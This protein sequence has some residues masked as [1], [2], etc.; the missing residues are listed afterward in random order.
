[1]AWKTLEAPKLSG[2]LSD[3]LSKVVDMGNIVT[4]ALKAAKSVAQVVKQ[5]SINTDPVQLALQAAAVGLKSAVDA[6]VQSFPSAYVLVVPPSPKVLIPASVKVALGSVTPQLSTELLNV[7]AKFAPSELTPEINTFLRQVFEAST[8]NGS[9]V[10][11]VL[12]S[13]N[14]TEDDSRPVL[15]Q[16]SYV[17][18]AYLVAGADG[19]ELLTPILSGLSAAM[20]SNSPV[21]LFPTDWP[22]PQGLVAKTVNASNVSLRWTRPS[23][24]QPLPRLDTFCRVTA[25]AIIRSES[26]SLLEASTAE[27]LFNSTELTEGMTGRGGATVV[28]VLE[29]ADAIDIV[30]FYIDNYEFEKGKAYY[31]TLAYRYLMGDPLSVSSADTSLG[32]YDMGFVRCSNGVK[33]HFSTGNTPSPRS[34]TGTPP[35]WVRYP[36]A[37]DIFPPMGEAIDIAAEYAAQ[38]LQTTQGYASAIDGYIKQLDNLITQYTETEQKLKDLLA[39]LDVIA[40][41]DLGTIAVRPFTSTTGGTSFLQTDIVRAFTESDAP[42]FGEDSFVTGVVLLGA[43]PSFAAFISLITGGST[44]T[45]VEDALKQIDVTMA[46]VKTSSF[47][48]NFQAGQ[49]PTP[50]PSSAGTP[51]IGPAGAYCYHPYEPSVTLGDDFQPRS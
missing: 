23:L 19:I 31:Y 8:G 13:L 35:D 7:S 3:L 1:M 40:K 51:A 27:A 17:A 30:D 24:T 38:A 10:K 22:A 4:E 18:G 46:N 33:V 9:F 37:V 47:G 5:V 14:D 15:G 11:A 41:L 45:L 16:D 36:R 20:F 12:E 48:D 34:S 29:I 49:V 42:K 50:P 32:G 44:A 2:S 6:L 43:S 21:S 25:I 28:K 39:Q 26:A